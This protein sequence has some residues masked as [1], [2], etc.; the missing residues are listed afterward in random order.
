[1]S[2]HCLDCGGAGG[3][4]VGKY[5]DPRDPPLCITECLCE[6][7]YGTALDELLEKAKDQMQW[8]QAELSKL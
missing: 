1:M 5:K 8:C 3:D 2:T 4:F 6:E 7:C